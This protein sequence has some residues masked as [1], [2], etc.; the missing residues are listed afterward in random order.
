MFDIEGLTF[1]LDY[2]HWDG[3]IFQMLLVEVKD[4]LF[5][6][7]EVC[8]SCHKKLEAPPGIEPGISHF[9]VS[10]LTSLSR[11]I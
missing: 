4:E 8:V 7:L 6:A 11:A 5:T 10:E 9:A 1:C 2:P 3:W